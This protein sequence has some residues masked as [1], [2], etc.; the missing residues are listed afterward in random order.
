MRVENH[1]GLTPEQVAALE[2]ELGPLR[3]LLDVMKWGLAQPAGTLSPQVVA[4]VVM[5]DE[6]S[7]DA[8]VPWRENLFL[9]FGAT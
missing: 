3:N 5:Q 7:H 8:I 6:F 4:E 1:A 9:V 2:S